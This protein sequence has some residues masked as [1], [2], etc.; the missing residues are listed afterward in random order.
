MKKQTLIKGTIILGMASIFAKFLGI[1]FRIPLQM[2]IGDEGMGYYQMSY[3]LYVTF[4]AIASGIPIAISNIISE[5]SKDTE[6]MVGTTDSVKLELQTQE[7]NIFTAIKSF[8]SITKAVDE[9]TPKMNA[10]NNSVE[11]LDNN[12]TVI[13]EKIEAASSISEEVSAS[14]EEIAASTHEMANS[15]EVVANSLNDLT[16]MSKK[17][18]D[19]VNKFKM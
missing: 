5:I 3:P 2:L 13:L 15:T 19:N 6:V 8:V 11:D 17:M 4:V 7:S 10:A 12:K 1:F 14:S 18:M 9:I 16:G